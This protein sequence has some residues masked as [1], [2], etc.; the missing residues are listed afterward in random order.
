[1]ENAGKPE[2]GEGRLTRAEATVLSELRRREHGASA[3]RLADAYRRLLELAHSDDPINS[4]LVAHLV[5]EILSATPGALGVELAHERLEYENRVKELSKAWPAKNRA[6]DAPPAVLADL[7]RLLDDQDRATARS[8]AGPRALLAQEDH[9]RAGFIPDPSIERW[10]YLSMRGSGLAHRLRNL[11]R[12]LPSPEDARRLAGELTATLL[13]TIAPFFVGI[14][15]LDALLELES[16]TDVDAERVGDLLRTASQY[17]YFFDRAGGQWLRPLIS[18]RRLLNSPPGLIDVGGGY[19]RAPD[20]P[21]GRFLARVAHADPDLVVGILKQVPATTNPRVVAEIVNIAHS[22]PTS[23]AVQLV[24]PIRARMSI[25]LAVEYAGIEAAAFAN[26]LAMAGK[27]D[28]ASGLLIAVVDAAIGSR[29][30]VKWHLEQVLGDPVDAIARAGGDIGRALH[31]RLRHALAQAGPARRYSVTWLWRIDR[32]SEYGADEIWFLANSLFRVLL[33]SPLEPARAQIAKLFGDGQPVVARVAFAAV[34]SRPELVEKSEGLLLEVARWDSANTTR[35]EF[36]QALAALWKAASDPA[37]KTLLHYAESAEPA[38]RISERLAMDHVANAPGP[39][40]VRR[41]WRSQLLLGVRDVIPSDWLNRLGPLDTVADE[42]PP[43]PVANWAGPVSPVTE[44]E[45]AT[46]EPDRLVRVLHDWSTAAAPSLD[47]PGPEGLAIAAASTVVSRLPEFAHLAPEVARLNARFV[48][49]I[50][51]ATE[52]GLRENQTRDREVAVRF[53][54]EIGEAFLPGNPA[55]IWS[56]E[57]KRDIAGIIGHAANSNI[58]D[59]PSSLTAL[60][61]LETLLHDIDPTLRSEERDL[62]GGHDVGMLALNSVRGAATTAAVELLLLSRRANRAEDADKTSGVLRLAMPSD[63]SRSVRAAIGIRLPW[64]LV[65]DSGHRSEWLLLLFGTN[66]PQP[67]IDAT[68]DAYLLY[69]RFFLDSAALLSDQYA[70]AVARLEPRPKDAGDRPHDRDEQLGVHLAM[71]HLLAMPAEA[72]GRWLARFYERAQGWLRA[73]V[74]RWIAQQAAATVTG[75]EVRKRAR[76]FL[77]NR[78]EDD[79]GALEAE[80]LKAVGWVARGTDAEGEVL[81][82]IVLPA[83][84]RTGGTTDDEAGVADLIA[85]CSVANPLAAAKALRLL[86]EGDAWQYVPHV[87]SDDLRRGLDVLIASSDPDA[88]QISESVVHTLGA[89]GFHEYRDLLRN[90]GPSGRF[91][92]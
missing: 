25:P 2:D 21:Q 45:L 86:V 54:L 55:D 41:R 40:E 10:V 53:A 82:L 15:E 23:H 62:A 72:D 71:A 20:W 90:V 3:P 37:R 38:A 76:V 39:Q 65:A 78:L 74:T 1:M 50:T 59:G 60:S 88:R 51:S 32:R 81:E 49:A 75:P 33:A 63:Y 61:L 46:M 14:G 47:A 42:G 84:E 91:E 29:R 87:A 83:L 73:R 19:V 7:R 13:A 12:K 70:A 18:V 35:Y 26:D 6:A 43:E 92:A 4:I 52:R 89:R 48:A 31:R 36:R 64:L 30:D 56:K 16:P 17:A 85:R 79:P 68:W 69:S 58:L 9:A 11:D 34:A 44:D 27:A 66:V 8:R 24:D 28:R 67:A 5:R 22:L 80:E 77:R 57:V